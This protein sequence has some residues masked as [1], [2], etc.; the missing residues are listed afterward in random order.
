MARKVFYSFHFDNDYW[1]VQQVR[2]IGS[3]EGQTILAPNVWEE[4]RKKG[5]A[6]IQKWID[7]NMSGRSCVIVLI[8][9]QTAG[10]EWVDYEIKKAWTDKRGLLGIYIHRLLDQGKKPSVKGA[11]P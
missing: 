4:I 5:K 9:S 1:R 7:E 3:V 8:G 10:R 6:A 11:N 2:N